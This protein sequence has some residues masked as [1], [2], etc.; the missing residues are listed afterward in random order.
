MSDEIELCAD[1]GVDLG[2]SV[3]VHVAPQRGNTVE[4]LLSV[5][6]VKMDARAALDDR[7]IFLRV[8]PHLGEGMPERRRVDPAQTFRSS[9]LP[10]HSSEASVSGAEELAERRVSL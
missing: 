7:R 3:P 9:F 6:I 8:G 5:K 2:M 10:V 1:G 4:I